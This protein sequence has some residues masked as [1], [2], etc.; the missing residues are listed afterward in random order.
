MTYVFAAAINS[1]FISIKKEAPMDIYAALGKKIREARKI[2]GITQEMLAEASG[3]SAHFLSTIETG[4]EKASLETVYK[5]SKALDIPMSRLFQFEDGI[6]KHRNKNFK[7]DMMMDSAGKNKQ[8][9]LEETI[10]DIYSNM[11]KYIK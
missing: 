10:K 8:E 11:K 6:K 2:S 1:I 4:R 3:I 5:I 7:L 9:F